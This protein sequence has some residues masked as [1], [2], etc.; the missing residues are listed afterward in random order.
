[1]KFC[2]VCGKEISTRDG[3]NRC[4]SCENRSK[5]NK[6]AIEQRRAKHEALTSLGLI[7]VRGK[8]GGIY[9]E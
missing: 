7:R 5:R 2:E 4:P 3:K 9:Y 1:M 8:L 6:R